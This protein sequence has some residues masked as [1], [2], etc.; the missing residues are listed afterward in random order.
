[1]A[2]TQTNSNFFLTVLL[3]Q[4]LGNETTMNHPQKKVPKLAI[5]LP[6]AHTHHHHYRTQKVTMLLLL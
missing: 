3:L 1:M 2:S 6:T 4:M 5:R